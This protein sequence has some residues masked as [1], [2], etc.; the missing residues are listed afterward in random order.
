MQ[1]RR[2]Q[3]TAEYA[4]VISIVIAAAIGIQLYV[5]R[6]MQAK[7]K[8]VS[9]FYSSVTDANNTISTLAQYEPYYGESNMHVNQQTSSF[10]QMFAGGQMKR[11]NINETTT[12]NG[13]T[14]QG[15][16]ITSGSGWN[17]VRLPG[18]SN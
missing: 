16:T 15:T 18:R 9:D 6:G 7:Y 14:K 11:T 3:S 2:G 8:Q 12:R 10:D 13:V 5:K 17:A 1:P 4:I